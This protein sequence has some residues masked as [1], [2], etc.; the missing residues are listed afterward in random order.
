MLLGQPVNN[1]VRLI[2]TMNSI[3]F[4]SVAGGKNSE[5]L[6]LDFIDQRLQCIGYLIRRERDLLPQ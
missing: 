1:E 5:L 3:D 6:Q 2:V 4:S